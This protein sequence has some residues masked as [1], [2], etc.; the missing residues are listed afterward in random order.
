[1][2]KIISKLKVLEAENITPNLLNEILSMYNQN[3][4]DFSK[5]IPEGH[6]DTYLRTCLLKEPIEALILKWDAGCETAIHHHYGF[7]GYVLVLSGEGLN[8]DFEYDET[9]QILRK[10]NEQHL[11][12]GMLVHELKDAV[13]Q[14][15]NISNKEPLI[16]FHLYHPAQRTLDNCLIFDIDKK[17][18]GKL[19]INAK[20]A[21][22][23]EPEENFIE[24]HDN[25][26]TYI[27]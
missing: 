1:M 6:S 8:I 27:D 4:I 17:R 22:W 24:I 12:P 18:I 15:K 5:Y 16:A 10:T 3:E 23:K 9:N 26:F 20:S 13:H 7:W 11:K 21:S 25:A 14:L 2:E 19:S